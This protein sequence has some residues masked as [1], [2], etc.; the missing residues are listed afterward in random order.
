MYYS[1]LFYFR[2][3][4]LA[5]FSF[6]GLSFYLIEFNVFSLHLVLLVLFQTRFLLSHLGFSRLTESK[7][8]CLSAILSIFQVLF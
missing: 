1:F 2:M 6:F 5:N 7:A 8:G 4:V 3:S